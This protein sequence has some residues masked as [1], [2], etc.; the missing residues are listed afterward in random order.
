MSLVHLEVL[1]GLCDG[2]FQFTVREAAVDVADNGSFTSDNI[3]TRESMDSEQGGVKESHV[4]IVP[5]SSSM[6]C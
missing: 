3:H 4:V 6:V 1:C 2:F 5:M